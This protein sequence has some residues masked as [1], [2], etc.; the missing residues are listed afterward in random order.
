MASAHLHWSWTSRSNRFRSS[1]GSSQSLILQRYES[2][3]QHKWPVTLL[4][5]P[6][7]ALATAPQA[8]CIAN[9]GT[10]GLLHRLAAWVTWLPK[11]LM[12]SV[13]LLLLV[14][15]TADIKP[16]LPLL[17]SHLLLALWRNPDGAAAAYLPFLST[18]AA[19]QPAFQQLWGDRDRRFSKLAIILKCAVLS[20]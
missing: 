19:S 1:R 4:T 13:P 5:L 20:I 9:S 16:R 7:G 14:S 6:T 11:R 10:K 18:S 2:N 3:V 8:F 12:W 17:Q 15:E